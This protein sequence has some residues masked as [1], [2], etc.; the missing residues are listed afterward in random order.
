MSSS[1]TAVSVEQYAMRVKH[2]F[3]HA[4]IISYTRKVRNIKVLSVSVAVTFPYAV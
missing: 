4:L 3:V 2:T 1:D